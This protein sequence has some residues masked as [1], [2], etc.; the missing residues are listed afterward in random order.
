MLKSETKLKKK[1]S[2]VLCIAIISVSVLLAPNSVNAI[3][4]VSG[5]VTAPINGSCPAQIPTLINGSFEDFSNPAEDP[6]VVSNLEGGSVYGK[7]HGYADGP[8]QILL[9]KPSATASAGQTAN[10]LTGWKSTTTL[11]ELQRQVPAYTDRHNVSGTLVTP[12]LNSP[13]SGTATTTT[14]SSNPSDY[15]DKYAPQAAEGNYWAELNPTTPSALYQDITVPSAAQVFWSIKHR[16]RTDSN[17]NEE[18]KVLIGP[19][20]NNVASLAQQ[21]PIQK[22]AP[23]NAN[24]YVGAPTYGSNSTSVLQILG[25]L[26]GGWNRFEGTY[27]ADNSQGAPTSR[28]LRLQFE[29]IRGG[30][31]WATFGNLLDDIQFSALLACPVTKSLQVGQT[32]SVDVT[33]PLG[34]S[35]TEKVSYGVRQSLS[36][37]GNSNAPSSQFA[38]SGN[39]VSFTPTQAGTFSVD[40]QVSMDFGGQTYSAAS[41]INYVVSADPNA[42]PT[43]NPSSN[44]SSSQLAANQVAT[45]VTA[46]AKTGAET[47]GKL[48]IA[49]VSLMF[50]FILL[51]TFKEKSN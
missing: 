13:A 5:S 2:L 47:S 23:T 37:L 32:A 49:L 39:T 7:W 19:V 43:A 8:D 10:Y 20:V 51:L 24:V 34:A 17:P 27:P 9:L 28:I 41:T 11:L 48:L 4:T 35:Q 36:A 25:T 45:P 31:G 21:T 42:T 33:G 44:P 15:F 29:S 12:S 14:I 50:G 1:L 30:N 46:L 38:T 6:N 18:M 16:G 22:Y 3:G 26:S 40:Y